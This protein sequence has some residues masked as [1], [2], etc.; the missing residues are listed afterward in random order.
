MEQEEVSLLLLKS[1]VRIRAVA[2]ILKYWSH[3]SCVWFLWI[4]LVLEKWH[5]TIWSFLDPFLQKF[6]TLL[7][8]VKVTEKSRAWS[9]E[10]SH[11]KTSWWWG[12]HCILY[13]LNFVYMT[14]VVF[15]FFN[16]NR[17]KKTWLCKISYVTESHL[18][19]QHTATEALHFKI[20]H[21]WNFH[22]VTGCWNL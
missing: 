11:F 20:Y 3:V 9:K 14:S 6:L 15:F 7:F 17:Q 16:K 8:S 18:E 13:V 1:R 21:C 4:R 12:M 5:Y 10:S 2:R 19:I 22:L